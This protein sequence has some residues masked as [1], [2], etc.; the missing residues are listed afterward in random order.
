MQY[1]KKEMNKIRLMKKKIN[2]KTSENIDKII[3]I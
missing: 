3:Y 2:I 1:R